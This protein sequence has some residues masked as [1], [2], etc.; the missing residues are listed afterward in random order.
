MHG[1]LI[2]LN[3]PRADGDYKT[4][5]V[6]KKMFLVIALA[7]V[8]FAAGA[9]TTEKSVKKEKSKSKTEQMTMKAHVC[10][11]ACKDGK[12]VYA[13]GEKGHVCTAACK[14]M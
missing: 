6:M 3:R 13:H 12:H 8:V 14:K 4:K 1:L 7:G 9:Q 2:N 5:I 10:T 11:S